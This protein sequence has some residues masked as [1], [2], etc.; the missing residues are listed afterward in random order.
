[1]CANINSEETKQNTVSEL[2]PLTLSEPI[3]HETPLLSSSCP[4]IFYYPFSPPSFTI[5]FPSSYSITFNSFSP[6]FKLLLILP[7]YPFFL[8][9]IVF[10]LYFFISPSSTSSSSPFSSYSSPLLF[11]S[12]ILLYL[13][14]C[15]N[16]SPTILLC[17]FSCSHFYP[18]FS[19]LHSLSS[20]LR[21]LQS[22]ASPASSGRAS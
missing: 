20:L 19:S 5:I 18:S 11:L 8:R 9:I 15:I 13:S 14:F 17:S 7:V 6:P 4:C 3:S 12:F 16:L 21:F 1:M 10:L 2:R 22:F